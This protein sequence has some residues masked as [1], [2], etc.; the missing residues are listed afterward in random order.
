MSS[1]NSN[2]VCDRIRGCLVGCALGDTIGLFT[3]FLTPEL[4]KANYGCPDIFP[5]P[6]I[7]MLKDSHRSKFVKGDWTDDTDQLLVIL[8]AWL[9]CN[10]SS[11]STSQLLPTPQQFGSR[12]KI[13]KHQGLSCIDKLPFGLGRTVGSVLTHP[14]FDKG[15]PHRAAVQVWE[16]SGRKLAANGAVMVK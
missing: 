7:D 11:N 5:F 1:S 2:D 15:D 16:K 12:L 6:S 4:T 10:S 14:D 3:E 9:H 8:L 13:W